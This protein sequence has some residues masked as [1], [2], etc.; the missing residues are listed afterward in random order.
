MIYYI[1]HMSYYKTIV[2]QLHLYY[3][4][5]IFIMLTLFT[6]LVIISSSTFCTVSSLNQVRLQNYNPYTYNSNIQSSEHYPES[7]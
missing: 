3:K 1:I 7:L 5:N 4:A 6:K 2:T